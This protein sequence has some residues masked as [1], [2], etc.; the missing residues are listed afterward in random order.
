M[1]L[2]VHLGYGVGSGVDVV[3]LLEDTLVVCAGFCAGFTWWCRGELWIARFGGGD[4]AV[5]VGVVGNLE[6]LFVVFDWET[7]FEEPLAVRRGVDAVQVGRLGWWSWFGFE[8]PR[9]VRRGT[10]G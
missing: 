6:A 2:R 8:S 5:G 10:H 7:A 9:G 4:R 3:A 1:H